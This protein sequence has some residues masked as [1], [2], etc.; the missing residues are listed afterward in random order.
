MSNLKRIR[1]EKRFLLREIA[2]HV[3]VTEQTV[4]QMESKGVKKID[5]AK[6]YAAALGVSWQ[7]II[8]A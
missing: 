7:D 5:T 2:A 3:G 1:K 4:Q 8:E 6:R